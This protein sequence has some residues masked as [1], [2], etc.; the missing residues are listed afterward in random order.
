MKKK[1][2]MSFCALLALA[3]GISFTMS[4]C[5]DDDDNKGNAPDPEVCPISLSDNVRYVIKEKDSNFE[6]FEFT[7]D[8][9]YIV[10]LYT[11]VES[12]S[13]SKSKIRKE[14]SIDEPKLM[15]IQGTYTL[16]GNVYTLDDFGKLSVI[17]NDKGEV[18]KIVIISEDHSISLSAIAEYPSE[19]TSTATQNL[20]HEWN[21]DSITYTHYVNGKVEKSGTGTIRE[22]KELFPE[23]FSE[24]NP[25]S[26]TFTMN[27]TYLVNYLEDYPQIARWRWTD[28]AQ[29]AIQYCWEYDKD[30]TYW[31]N[32]EGTGI[33]SLS[34]ENKI[35]T[36][37]EEWGDSISKDAY[38]Y[39]L[40]TR[41]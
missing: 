12:G 15:V 5:G 16:D 7:S 38:K 17:A 13:D 33:I 32:K 41:K 20:C 24:F 40:S 37:Y 31:D 29:N 8:N 2:L 22:M 1:R 35:I 27:G 21:V 26:I 39:Y 23:E 18:E 11:T 28:S 4:S 30:K 10:T 9:K 6:S 14:S 25:L 36:A 19:K 34:Y 3:A